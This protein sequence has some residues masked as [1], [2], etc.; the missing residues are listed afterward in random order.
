MDA[1][2]ESPKQSHHAQEL[3]PALVLHRVLLAHV[4]DGVEYATEQ[5]QAVPQ[6]YVMGCE[7]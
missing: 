1:T 7:Q 2:D 3:H 4:G 5:D 6:D